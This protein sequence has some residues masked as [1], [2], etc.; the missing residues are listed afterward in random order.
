MSTG[1]GSRVRINRPVWWPVL[2]ALPLLLWLGWVARRSYRLREQRTARP[3]SS[4]V[5]A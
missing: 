2:A 3:L 4:E 1:N 5:A